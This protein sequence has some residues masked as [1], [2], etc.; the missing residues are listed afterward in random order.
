MV[1]D[2]ADVRGRR[3]DH[4]RFGK[5]SRFATAE[6]HPPGDEERDAGRRD[7]LRCIK[8]RRYFRENAERVSGE[9][10]AELHQEGTVASSQFSPVVSAR[11]ARWICSYSVPAD[12]RRTRLD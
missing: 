5:L 8:G 2:A 7:D 11:H 12:Y 4:R 6:G 10:R 9:S 3:A 1:L